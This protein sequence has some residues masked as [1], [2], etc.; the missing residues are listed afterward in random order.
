MSVKEV[1]IDSLIKPWEINILDPAVLFTT[2]YTAL[3]YAIFYS[4]FEAFPLVFPEMYG[5]NPGITGLTIISVPVG[6]MLSVLV[7]LLYYHYFVEPSLIKNGAPIPEVW[8]QPGL[9]GNVL[10]PIGLF[11]FGKY[12]TLLD[13]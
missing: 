2:F 3:C 13:N 4:F 12:L 11:T 8:L 1:L 5:M 10:L 9:V 7:C 6:V